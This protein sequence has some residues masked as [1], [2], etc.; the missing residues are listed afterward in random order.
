[1]S[2]KYS[3]LHDEIVEILFELCKETK[4][5]AGKPIYSSV[6]ADHIGRKYKPLILTAYIGKKK[7]PLAKKYSPDVWA[8]VKRK[9]FFDICEVWHSET[10]AEAVE[11]ILFSSLV[12]GVRYLHIVCTGEN[13]TSEEAEELV[14]F[15]LHRIHDEEGNKLLD[16]SDVYIA[17]I[18]E[19]LWDDS[20]K[21]K[22]YLKRELAF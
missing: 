7:K 12:G 14:D 21:I 6:Y 8:Q 1:M 17:D 13:L 22:K 19:K 16:A 20:V 3:N 5:D 10:E 4:T 18:P 15:V 9:G 11:D 2:P